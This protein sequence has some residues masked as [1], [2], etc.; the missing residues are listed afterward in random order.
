ML[1]G[2]HL[3]HVK[4]SC[5][6]WWLRI[7]W[8]ARH[9]AAVGD[10]VALNQSDNRRSQHEHVLKASRLDPRFGKMNFEHTAVCCSASA[11]DFAEL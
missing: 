7:H 2:E 9:V 11:S 5:F 6:V 8:L 10:F 4:A 3:T 1:F